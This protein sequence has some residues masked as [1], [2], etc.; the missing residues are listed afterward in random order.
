[1]RV[2]RLGEDR[3][4]VKILSSPHGCHGQGGCAYGK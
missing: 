2:A 1:M 3:A 4:R